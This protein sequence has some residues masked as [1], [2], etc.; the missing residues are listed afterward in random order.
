MS[1]PGAIFPAVFELASSLFR[2][3]SASSDADKAMIEAELKS[4]LESLTQ[5]KDKVSAAISS[6]DAETQAIIDAARGG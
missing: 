2:T 6:R 5:A 3:W 4:S 1:M